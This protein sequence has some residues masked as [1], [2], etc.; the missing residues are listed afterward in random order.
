[1]ISDL[2]KNSQPSLAEP[3]EIVELS[4]L[5]D[6]YGTLLKENH[7]SIFED[8]VW[9]NLSLGEI[10]ADRKITRQGVYD[11]IRRCRKSLRDYEERLQLLHKFEQMKDRI[12]KIESIAREAGNEEAAKA[13][14]E[15][16]EELLDMY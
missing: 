5:Y 2:H 7:R 9:N 10:A 13:I 4:V 6:F 16:A 3:D 1:M 8:Y 12:H 15:L 11:V 14:T